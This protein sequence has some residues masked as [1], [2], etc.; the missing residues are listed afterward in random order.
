MKKILIIGTFILLL[1]ISIAISA[2]LIT[3]EKVYNEKENF[4]DKPIIVEDYNKVIPRPP[5]DVIT[6]K[7]TF[8][9]NGLQIITTGVDSIKTNIDMDSKTSRIIR[10]DLKG[11]KNPNDDSITSTFILPQGM[12]YK[13]T[14]WNLWDGIANYSGEFKQI[15]INDSLEWMIPTIIFEQNGKE[16][17]WNTIRVDKSTGRFLKNELIYNKDNEV[18]GIRTTGMKG[19]SSF[20]F[21]D[22]I[23]S[24][25]RIYITGSSN[26]TDMF[27]FINNTVPECYK[28]NSTGLDN[29][30]LSLKIL[31]C[32]IELNVSSNLSCKD[33][34]IVFDVDYIS[35]GNAGGGLR[36]NNNTILN[37]TNCVIGAMNVPETHFTIIRP[38]EQPHPNVVNTT[39]YLTNV[40][41]FS[42]NPRNETYMATVVLNNGT[43]DI[44]TTSGAGI[45]R[46]GF[47]TYIKG[48]DVTIN[49]GWIANTFIKE[50][51]DQLT[52]ISPI[53]RT[54]FTNVFN[55]PIINLTGA[56]LDCTGDKLALATF[57]GLTLDATN[58]IYLSD[59]TGFGT[60]SGYDV[61][62]W[63]TYEKNFTTNG[64]N[65]INASWSII[66]TPDNETIPT[67]TYTG[68]GDKID[69]TL[70]A[71]H[72]TN[73]N[74]PAFFS[75]YD[76]R[77]NFTSNNITAR[78][79]P[80]DIKIQN[81][82]KVEG[83]MYMP[84]NYETIHLKQGGGVLHIP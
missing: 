14:S 32:E 37:F 73:F 28:E 56:Y 13:R 66:N 30:N 50:G 67:F 6:D 41:I 63:W 65:K 79:M 16:I 38:A 61:R 52:V 54:C 46:V 55:S 9:I 44:I 69:I 84:E 81:Q 45:G 60:I 29:R 18:I 83:Y 64:D 39:Q 68:F 62:T 53:G 33:K 27:T 49:D 21:D 8:Y 23:W 25:T 24:G 17:K 76:A 40:N 10:L 47:S 75:I 34:G 1:I 43:L 82:A 70:I 7:N 4:I 71:S 77:A 58:P 12:K 74:L 2:D 26:F 35:F 59:Q 57:A 80:S 20:E 78:D 19:L 31:S 22:I 51:L 72:S 36:Y 42:I 15:P 5:L 11:T 3:S 48:K